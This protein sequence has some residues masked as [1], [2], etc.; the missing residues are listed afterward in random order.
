MKTL[1]ES[2]LGDLEDNLKLSDIIK[3][4]MKYLHDQVRLLKN[5]N[6]RSK[7]PTKNE[8]TIKVNNLNN[9]LNFIGYDA[10]SINIKF[11]TV[12]GWSG[13]QF[14]IYFL[15]NADE[16][17][18]VHKFYAEIHDEKISKTS[19]MVKILKEV[20]KDI[21][22]FQNFLK[23]IESNQHKRINDINQLLP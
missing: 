12:K 18:T 4:E 8:H 22:T 2:L 14:Y 9:L 3:K 21:K 10:D 17:D 20:T 5:Y 6:K 1:K 15:H 7:S 13:L 11:Y 23:N 19:D 16:Y